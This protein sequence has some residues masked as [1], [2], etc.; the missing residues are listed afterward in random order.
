MAIP[1]GWLA[2]YFPKWIGLLASFAMRRGVLPCLL[3]PG[4]GSAFAAPEKTGPAFLNAQ[5]IEWSLAF[6]PWDIGAE[7]RARYEMKDDAGVVAN[8]DFVDGIAR[9]REANYL[10]EK[11][12]LASPRRRVVQAVEVLRDVRQALERQAGDLLL[13]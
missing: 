6:T 9:G 5:L 2:F 12:H 1:A 4:F 8:T 11:L 3:L 10:R 7:V 13:K